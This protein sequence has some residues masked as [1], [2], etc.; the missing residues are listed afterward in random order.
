MGKHAIFQVANYNKNMKINEKNLK[1]IVSF[2]ALDVFFNL[3]L[4]CFIKKL[5]TKI[6]K[7]FLFMEKE[8]K[9]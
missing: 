3:L 1:H 2:T 6:I 9:I 5:F 4:N 7:I 8:K